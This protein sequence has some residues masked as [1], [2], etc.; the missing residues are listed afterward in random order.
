MKIHN[1]ELIFP[2]FSAVC[3]R[4]KQNLRNSYALC[5]VPLCFAGSF[6]RKLER[7]HSSVIINADEIANEENEMLL[8]M[9]YKCQLGEICPLNVMFLKI[10]SLII[11]CSHNTQPK[12]W[13][14]WGSTIIWETRLTPICNLLHDAQ[15]TRNLSSRNLKTAL[16]VAINFRKDQN[17]RL[18]QLQL[19]IDDSDVVF[20]GEII[21][22]RSRRSAWRVRARSARLLGKI[23]KRDRQIKLQE[24]ISDK[25][26]P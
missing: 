1:H 17:L 16:S 7:S 26:K 9:V 18:M 20:A 11:M 23:R 22:K 15:V 24:Q 19:L 21:E 6:T 4:I 12:N 14:N 2:M 13:S 8:F 3:M 5:I 10:F 25:V